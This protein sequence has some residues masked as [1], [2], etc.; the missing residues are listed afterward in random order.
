MREHRDGGGARVRRLLLRDRRRRREDAG[1]GAQVR[2]AQRVAD[3]GER[4]AHQVGVEVL[5]R[6][7]GRLRAAVAVEDAK[8]RVRL[9]GG[10]GE[11]DDRPVL[12]VAPRPLRPVAPPPQPQVAHQLAPRAAARRDRRRAERRRL[13]RRILQIRGARRVVGRLVRRAHHRRHL[14]AHL[15]MWRHPENCVQLLVA[16][17][18]VERAVGGRRRRAR[19]ARR[20][21]RRDVH[22]GWA[23]HG[24]RDATAAAPAAARY[25]SRERV[26]PLELV[27]QNLN[28]QLAFLRQRSCLPKK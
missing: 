25:A 7:V 18:L 21:V 28:E 24:A 16:Q 23:P 1:V 9:L 11:A 13:H 19:R 20:R 14:H 8:V 22:E 6:V 4:R 17:P 27:E 26:E 10:L 12:L 5:D 2:V 3:V 15:V